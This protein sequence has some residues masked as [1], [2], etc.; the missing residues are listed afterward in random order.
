MPRRAAACLVLRAPRV[1]AEA[2]PCLV[3]GR[4]ANCTVPKGQVVLD[5]GK[6]DGVVQIDPRCREM[7]LR[8][9]LPIAPGSDADADA[10]AQAAAEVQYHRSRAQLGLLEGARE[11]VPER[12][13][14]NIPPSPRAIFAALCFL[15]PRPC[16]P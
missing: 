2:C 1:P 14:R 6:A 16:G 3:Y 8:A 10:E 4:Q 9:V 5:V 13:R 11:V 7:G 12:V 15:P